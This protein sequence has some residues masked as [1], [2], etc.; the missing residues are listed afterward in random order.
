M[1]DSLVESKQCRRA[2]DMALNFNAGLLSGSLK[3]GLNTQITPFPPQDNS[4][5]TAI[6]PLT[7]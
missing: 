7:V 4:L 2:L 1:L 3:Q 5:S 6:H